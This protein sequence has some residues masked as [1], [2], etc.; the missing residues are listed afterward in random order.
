MP[1]GAV[2]A[3][4]PFDQFRHHRETEWIGPP[5]RLLDGS[6]EARLGEKDL[7]IM[8]GAGPGIF[9][10]SFL[11]EERRLPVDEVRQRGCI[12]DRRTPAEPVE[13]PQ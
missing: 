2:R 8:P 5:T 6:L 10:N 12:A 4:H 9:I 1:V 11:H 7:G 13:K 3:Q